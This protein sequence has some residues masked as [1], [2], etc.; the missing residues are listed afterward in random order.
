MV[1]IEGLTKAVAAM[2][3]GGAGESLVQVK[4]FLHRVHGV[5]QSREVQSFL[6][7]DSKAKSPGSGEVLGVLKQMKENFETNLK[8]LQT[9]ESSA[10]KAYEEMKAAKESEIS[11]SNGMI[12][13]DKA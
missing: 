6:Q 4:Q 12:D 13:Q 9:D 8:E 2:S 5:Q 10:K 11:G 3:A 7:M 1:S